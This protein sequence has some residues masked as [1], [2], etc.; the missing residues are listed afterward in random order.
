MNI[1][2]LELVNF[3][4]YESLKIKFS[5]KINIL[6]GDNAQG[7]TNILE[8]IY[9]LALTKSYRS[10]LDQELIK[11]DQ[12]HSIIKGKI[13]R[14]EKIEKLEVN[15]G[16][17][18]KKIKKN[19]KIVKKYS[20]Y[21]SNLNVILFTPDDLDIIKGSPAIRRK[22]LN[23]EIGQ[24]DNTYLEILNRYN[25]LLKTRN[26]Y[27]KVIGRTKKKDAMYLAILTDKLIEEAVKIYKY[28]YKFIRQLNSKLNTISRKIIGK[29]I[30]IE[31]SVQKNILINVRKIKE[32]LKEEY[33]KNERK[34]IMFGSTLVGP[35][36]DDIIFTIDNADIKKY[37]SQG[38]QRAA[39]LSLKLAEIP[40]FKKKTESLP[41]LLLDDVLSE[42]DTEKKNNLLKYINKNIQTIIT[43]TN[44]KNID[45]KT[46][47]KAK[48]FYIENAK[49]KLIDEVKENGKEKWI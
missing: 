47:K 44:I 38:Q 8:A 21:I 45:Q 49:V 14:N 24:L 27:L 12:K 11:F 35:H 29:T 36:K 17:F 23:I 28:R 15:I 31:Y 39:V 25:H 5:D 22:F 33:K 3:K 7:K 4:N 10:L 9:V 30:A 42:F 41:I 6:Y 18:E 16:V 46:L 13:F 1:R 43:T 2:H 48:K 26:E 19:N 37:A 34:E 40:I 20:D 32:T